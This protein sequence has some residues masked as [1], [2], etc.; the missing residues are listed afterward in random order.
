MENC[1]TFIFKMRLNL[2]SKNTQIWNKTT[3]HMKICLERMMWPAFFKY[4]DTFKE[5]S[6]VYNTLFIKYVAIY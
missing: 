1:N 2:K 6:A 4:K 3:T 5:A